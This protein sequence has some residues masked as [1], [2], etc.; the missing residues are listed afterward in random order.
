MIPQ[1]DRL[2]IN[3]GPIYIRHHVNKRPTT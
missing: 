2:H 3:A 1:L